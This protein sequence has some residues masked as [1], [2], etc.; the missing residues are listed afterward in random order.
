MKQRLTIIDALA[1]AMDVLEE[2][3]MA[4]LAK[5]TATGLTV[6]QVITW[7]RWQIAD[8]V[9]ALPDANPKWK[10]ESIMSKIPEF[11]GRLVV[12]DTKDHGTYHYTP[13]KFFNSALSVLV[14][15]RQIIMQQKTDALLLTSRLNK[16][17]RRSKMLLDQ[18]NKA[19]EH[20]AELKEENAELRSRVQELN[21]DKAAM[22][23]RLRMAKSE[24]ADLRKTV[25]LL[26]ETHQRRATAVRAQMNNVGLILDGKWDAVMRPFDDA[27]ELRQLKRKLDL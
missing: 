26:E 9:A 13:I 6:P 23:V 22:S 15:H 2:R 1:K 25:H 11:H 5:I 18:L 20:L 4:Y 24:I 16:E 17:K 27:E 21:L 19:K 12:V 14:E 10:P 8:V 3:A 7:T